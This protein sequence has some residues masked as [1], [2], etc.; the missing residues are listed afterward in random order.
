MHSPQIDFDTL[1]LALFHQNLV[2][3]SII[4]MDGY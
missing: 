4:V 3:L 1:S 2:V